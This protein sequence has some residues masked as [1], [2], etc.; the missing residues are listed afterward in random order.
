VAPLIFPLFINDVS[1]PEKAA[2]Q[3]FAYG[4][5]AKFASDNGVYYLKGG[6]AESTEESHDMVKAKTVYNL[7]CQASRLDDHQVAV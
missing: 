1:T 6:K 2:E 4:T 7:A 3:Y 5:D